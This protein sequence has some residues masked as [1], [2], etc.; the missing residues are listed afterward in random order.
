MKKIKVT[1]KQLNTLMEQS[2]SND[3]HVDNNGELQSGEVTVPEPYE[4][5]EK[6]ADFLINGDTPLLHPD[7]YQNDDMYRSFVDA[8]HDVL[9]QRMDS[10]ENSEREETNPFDMSQ[11]QMNESI[12]I[13]KKE[14]LR[15][16]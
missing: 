14:F 2:I 6:V 12:E 11:A 5:A 9:T 4:M 15:F 3:F 10:G 1:Q 8:L 13:L 7:Y 16:K